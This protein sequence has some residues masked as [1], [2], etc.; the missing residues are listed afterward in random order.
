[1]EGEGESYLEE[2]IILSEVGTRIE[3]ALFHVG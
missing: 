1:M 3:G 2:G